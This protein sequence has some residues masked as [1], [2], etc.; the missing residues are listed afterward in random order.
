M[1][2]VFA[3][4]CSVVVGVAQINVVP[5]PVSVVEHPG[6]YILR[7]PCTLSFPA[8]DSVLLRAA[9]FCAARLPGRVSVIEG[10][11]GAVAFV[12]AKMPA[13]G[14]KLTVT[15]KGVRIEAGD[16]AGAIYG[17]QTLLQLQSNAGIPLVEITDAPRFAYRGMHLDC[18]RHFF[19]IDSVKRYL[20][21]MAMHKLN[22]FH[23]HLTDDEGWRIESK[24]YPE[25]N[26]KASWR[27]DRRGEPWS[28]RSPIDRA[29]GETP[30]YGGYYT[31]DEIRDLLAYAAERGIQVIPEIETPGHSSAVFAAY[32]ELSCLGTAQ[33]APPGGYFP[34]DQASCYCAG[35]EAVFTF[36]DG[37]LGEVIDLFPD[38]PYIHIGG[39]E[40]YKRFWRNCPKCAERIKKEGLKDYDELQSYFI[41]RVDQIVRSKGKR[42]IGWDEILEGGLVP[43]ATVMSWRGEQFGLQAARAGND[44]VMS[45]NTYLYFDYYQNDPL[46]EPEALGAV[47]SLERVYSYDPVPPT[48]DSA[49]ATHILGVQANLWSEY[50][51]TWSDVERMVLP[52]MCALAEVAWTP[53]PERNWADFARR[54]EVQKRRFEHMGANYHRRGSHVVRFDTRT[55]SNQFWVSLFAEPYRAKIRY[56]TDGSTPT[57]A[58][59]LY[60]DPLAVTDVV[61]IRAAI[62]Q[63][64]GTLS[65]QLS[66]RTLG[67]HKAIG[68]SIA[69]RTA[70]S[71]AYPGAKG[72]ATLLDGLTGTLRHDDG[73]MQGFNNRNFDL[74]V[75]L[76]RTDTVQSVG[77]SFLQSAGTWIYLPTE[78]IV[79][80]STDGTTWLPLGRVASAA[81]AHTM[82]TLRKL[83]VVNGTATPARYIHIEGINL[84]TPEGLP[85][86]GTINWNFADEIIVR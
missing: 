71:E 34:S 4:L 76:H 38:A 58:S 68:A 84:P 22:R 7:T 47:L 27:V 25:L 50:L 54:V 36:L 13:E 61:T 44:V 64:D 35:N 49:T 82:P 37:V 30:T 11:K 21:Y 77:V 80:L 39:D 67:R 55:D 17:V 66:E 73:L 23:W 29:A 24:R 75:D 5:R 74:V 40:V 69:Y 65:E 33:E 62:E 26:K 51:P 45:P 19:P 70:P 14:Y 86:A 46:F 53:R 56:T 59:P 85:G 20:D 2:V 8:G 78:L 63:A 12:R 48:L 6:V 41:G 9:E 15:K 72:A 16:Y 31:H 28:G 81:D 42:I 57:L 10:R 18:S 3:L 79:S 1:L 43:S 83:L 52:R 32:P 60:R